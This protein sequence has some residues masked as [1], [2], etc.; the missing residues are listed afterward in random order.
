MK[1]SMKKRFTVLLSLLFLF[2]GM[3]MAQIQVKGTV[4]S[5]DDGEP[6]PGVAVKVEGT[7]IGTTTNMD[8]QFVISIPEANSRL[9]ISHIGMVPRVMRARNG[10][11]VELESDN[12]VL[13][14]VMVVAYGTQKKSSFT[15]AASTIKSEKI[16]TLQVAELGKA[17]EGQVAGVQISSASGT[18]GSS[19]TIIVRGI[20]SI[21][22]DQEPLII[23]D[24]APY[25][26]SLNSIPTQD[27][28]SMTILKDAAANSMYGARGANGVLLITTKRAKGGKTRVE[29]EGRWGFNTRGVPNYDIIRDP[30]EYYEMAY[31]AYRN[32]MIPSMG[33]AAAS[34]FAAEHLIN[35]ELRYNVYKNVPNNQIIDPTTGRLNPNATE[36]LWYDDWTEEPFKRG[37]RQEYNVNVT[38]GTDKTQAYFSAGYLGDEGYVPG[39][40]FKRFSSRMKVDQEVN[41]YIK[42]GLNLGYVRTDMHRFGEEGDGYSNIFAFSQDI[43]PIYPVYEY[44]T[45]GVQ[46]D[47]NGNRRYDWGENR[48]FGATQNP[49]AAARENINQGIRDNLS[50][51]GYV[52]F[53]FLKDFKFTANVAYDVFN[54]TTI[55]FD[56]P[57][58]GDA[59]NVDGRA[60][61][62]STRYEALNVNQM[63]DW[64]HTFGNHGVHLLFVHE[65]KKDQNRSFSGSKSY[66]QDFHNPDLS[67]FVTM[68]GLSSSTAETALEGYLAKGEYEYD[69]R[70]YFTA[71]IRRDAS[72]RFAPGK[73]RWGTFWAVGGAWRV[74]EEPFFKPI[75]KVFTNLKLKASYGTQGNENIGYVTAYKDLYGISPLPDNQAGYVKMFRGNPDLTWEKQAMFNVGFEAGFF[76]RLNV[77]FD[78]FVKTNRDLL[79][80]SPLPLSGGDPTWIYR[81]EVDMRNTG[82]ELEVNADVFDHRNL[83]WNVALNLTHYK[84]ELLRLPDSKPEDKFP[85]GFVRGNYWWKKGGSI[86]NFNGYEYVGV[87]PTTGE[88][89]YRVMV[90]DVDANGDLLDTKH[91]E[92]VNSVSSYESKDLNKSA[93]PDLSG[94]LSTSL[95]VYGF[96]I[97]VQTAFQIG[98]WVR[99]SHYATLMSSSVSQGGNYH[100]DMFQRWTPSHTDTDIPKLV[101]NGQDANISDYS[102]FFLTKASYFSLKNVTIGYT[103]PKSWVSKAG[104]ERLRIYASGE[105]VWLL[106]KRKGLDPRQSMSGLTG[107]VYSP[108][109]AYSLGLNL[110][111]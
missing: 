90:N 86:Y 95:Y 2:V 89:Q 84:N 109:S 51:R 73:N 105:N 8:G 80:A 52:E 83:K 23:L 38:G 25:E 81:N 54:M 111:F 50:T 11:R 30:G 72:S 36:R 27:I 6:L 104:I 4:V 94:G 96:D 32:S 22:A 57:I 24:G 102:D 68:D 69:Q 55:N 16:Q 82:F 15:G 9:R 91:E 59:I 31:E 110:S 64:N 58:G 87:N 42:A 45:T 88:P 40:D 76:H 19:S 106:S 46:Y 65:N 39:S 107:S 33:Y 12:K 5:A 56:T 62:S 97:S 28:E 41:D 60:S 48:P 47:A 66:A 92:I 101:Y 74:N 77:N 98:G 20:G 63:L 26:G 14:E 103:F 100:R 29:F 18:P 35:D 71:S 99:D 44:T 78:F 85:D 37:F 53:N 108:M 93:I 79:Y 10:M 49:L 75:S 3:A 61:R 67:N 43:A 17:L 34:Q 70:Y 1:E 21:N 13:D 7:T